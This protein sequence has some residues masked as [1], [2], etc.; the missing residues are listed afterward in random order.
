M[1]F[2][3]NNFNIPTQYSNTQMANTNKVFS[4]KLTILVSLGFILITVIIWIY[5]SYTI[6][7]YSSDRVGNKL[8]NKYSKIKTDIDNDKQYI[9]PIN[10]KVDHIKN[11]ASANMQILN[12]EDNTVISSSDFSAKI[13]S[14]CSPLNLTCVSL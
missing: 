5:W 4:I 3:N 10:V 12:K 14:D 2:A 1:S 7:R 8:L 9:N 11:I 13:N 6:Y